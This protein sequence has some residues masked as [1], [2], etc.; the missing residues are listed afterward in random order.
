MKVEYVAFQSRSER[1]EY[2]ANRF[3][4]LL[5]GKILDVG[6]DKA[7]LKKL[8]PHLDYTGMDVSGDP[9]IRLNLEEVDRLPF[10]EGTFDCVVCSDVLE[11][12]DKFHHIFGELIRVAKKYIIISLPNNWANARIP[13][14]RGKGSFGHYGLPLEPPQD[15]HKWFFGLSEAISFV[16]GQANKFPIAILASHVTE[17]PRPSLIRAVRRLGYPSQERY[18]NRYAHTLWVVL[19]KK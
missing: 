1:S 15:R 10:E 18:L 12:L 13:I 8:L 16:K 5:A 17:K 2:I 19:E 3:R 9:D 7:V 11:H 14:A 6:C 4:P